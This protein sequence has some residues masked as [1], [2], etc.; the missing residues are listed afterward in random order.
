MAYGWLRLNKRFA[1]NITL[2]SLTHYQTVKFTLFQN[3]ASNTNC[4]QN[5]MGQIFGQ[6]VLN[7]RGLFLHL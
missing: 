6:F 2:I 3:F 5:L 4:C 7:V 1:L